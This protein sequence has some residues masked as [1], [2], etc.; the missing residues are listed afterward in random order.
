MQLKL[1]R[2]S[3]ILL[4][5]YL[6]SFSSKAQIGQSQPQYFTP[7]LVPRSP[8]ATGIEKFGTYPVN[9]FTGLPDISIP[10]YTVEAGGF[11][12]P[13]TL[14]YH[15]SGIKISDVAGWV[16]LGWSLSSGGQISRKTMGAPDDGVFG[17]LNMKGWIPNNESAQSVYGL[18]SLELA[19]KGQYDLQPD[20][21]SYDFPGHGGKFFFDG[22]PGNNYA[23]KFVPFAPLK[24]AYTLRPYYSTTPPPLSGMTNITIT[25]E[26]G[27]NY[28][29]GDGG[30]E[31]TSTSS[32]GS[33][34]YT[35]AASAWKIEN[36]I[37]QNR[38]DTVGFTYQADT[39]NYPLADAEI[40]TVADN[41]AIMAQG[42]PYSA[43]YSQVPL[44]PG[45]L[46]N[47]KE[48]L[49]RQIN[50]KNG[51]VIFD[52]DPV[53]RTDLY[54]NGSGVHGLKDIKIYHYNYATKAMVL[55]KTIVFYE[56]YFSNAGSTRLRLDSIQVHDNVGNTVQHYRFDY[57]TAISLPDYSSKAQD[58]W[59]YYN[60]QDGN[61]MLTPQQTIQYTNGGVTNI[62]IGQANRNSD[63][64]KMQAYML[65]GIHYPTGG[66]TTFAY[67]TN[68]FYNSDSLLTLAGGLRVRTISSYDGINPVPI[69]KT[70]VYNQAKANFIDDNGNQ[71]FNNYFSTEQTHRYYGSST[72]QAAYPSLVATERVRSFSSTPHCDLEGWDGSIVVYQS[73]SEYIGTPGNNIGRTDYLFTYQ[74]DQRQTASAFGPAVYLSYFFK[75]GLLQNKREFINKGNGIY[76]IAR[77]ITN[78]YK[79]FTE[80]SYDTLGFTVQKMNYNEGTAGNPIYPGTANVD[81]SN[82]YMINSYAIVSDANYLTGTT[83]NT[84]DLNDTTKFT[85]I[86]EKYHYDNFYHQQIN[87]IDHIDSKGDTIVTVKKY[88][89]D[90]LTIPSPGTVRTTNSALLDSM[91]YKNMQAEVIEKW[92]SLKSVGTSVNAVTSGQLNTYKPSYSNAIVPATIS[93]LSLIQPLTNFTPAVVA[94]GNL[95]SD[96]R[97]T[98]MI[99]FDQYDNQNNIIQ[100]TPRN[101]TPV[102][103]LWDY[104]S[105]YPVA[106]V[107]DATTSYAGT[108]QVAYT[109][110]EANGKGN[111]VYSGT[112]LFNSTAPTGS[113]V[114]LLNTGAISLNNT[115]DNTKSY[116]L[117]YWSSNGPATVNAGS[118]L[119]GSPISTIN[120]WTCY[121]YTVPTGTSSIT[122]SGN[123]TIDELSLYPTAAQMT[124]YTYT[125]LLGMT[126]TTAPNGKTAYYEYDNFQRLMNIKDQYRNIVKSFRYNYAGE[127]YGNNI[128]GTSFSNPPYV[129][130]SNSSTYTYVDE[131][132]N[133]QTINGYIFKTFS[134]AACTIPYTLQTAI[135]VNYQINTFTT[136]NYTGETIPTTTSNTI[137]IAA[138]SNQSNNISLN[139]NGCGGSSAKGD[140]ATSTVVLLPGTTY[141]LETNID[142]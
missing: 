53:H 120:G 140:C 26:H 97:Y 100:Y 85:S 28:K 136:Y 125:P 86:T 116:V 33:E 62:T 16:G 139:V 11:S 119:T 98:Q 14:S 137:S 83:T 74:K 127:T 59:G 66:Y 9:E 12:I 107:K 48:M 113:M 38:R 46:S 23:P 84:Y 8:S 102:S 87:R 117:T 43:S 105:G 76:Q 126:S 121:Q 130:M 63:S 65:T 10:L 118:I 75:R 41:I 135:T 133:S 17:Y 128:G 50:F 55:Q 77:S 51:M 134:D 34:T 3:G 27:N 101:T 44:T 106:Q 95:A 31:V 37:S 123:V 52:L 56:G 111:W 69:V 57:N 82:S 73:V 112:P 18:D 6:F 124:T 78:T 114:Y 1:L 138:G 40:Y 19:S 110:F 71:F 20:I 131:N 108:T 60:G 141:L 58:Y 22:S 21:Y 5:L 70:Y 68:Q 4:C 99:S 61:Q 49:P 81:D 24:I 94:S 103:I 64:T 67:Q 32:G 104:Q 88:P 96:S 35:I 89:A 93:T 13:I 45:N 115:L 90:Y 36:M 132:G 25:D 72:Q 92:D 91:Y 29:F 47:V 79:A 122:I 39:L 7:A 30:T 109:S 2:F 129:Q 142:D 42:S 80:I 15:T 54:S